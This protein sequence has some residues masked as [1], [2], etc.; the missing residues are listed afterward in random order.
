M[1]L[2]RSHGPLKWMSNFKAVAIDYEYYLTL[3]D[4]PQSVCLTERQM[5]VLS[6]QNTYTAWLTRWYNTDDITQKTVEF[7]AAEIEGL[8]MCGCGIP[9]PSVTDRINS[10][11]YNNTVSNTYITNETTYHTDGDTLNTL[12]P[13]MTY[14]GGDPADI[15]RMLCLGLEMLLKTVISQA[16]GVQDMDEN[17]QQDLVQQLG[18]AMGALAG[19]GSLA[20]AAGGSAA[21]VVAA[22]GGPWTLLGLA[23]GGIAVG[24]SSL[25]VS[26]DIAALT[27]EEAIEEVLCTLRE[28]A[29]NKEPSFAIFQGLLTPNTFDPGSNAEA[30]AAIVQPFLNNLTVYLQFMMVMSDLYAT[31][32]LAALPECAI[33]IDPVVCA[34]RDGYDFRLGNAMFTP[35]VGRASYV[36]GQGWTKGPLPAS[37][38]RIGIWRSVVPH[39]TSIT[40]V[41]KGNV[42]AV[43][44]YSSTGGVIGSLIGQD[45]IPTVVGDIY[46]WNIPV[47]GAFAGNEIM[48]DIGSGSDLAGK[49][50]IYFC[51]N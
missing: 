29:M 25:F 6:V 15:N 12:A 47:V 16:Q 45:T 26:T 22:I 10:Q 43:R 30:L 36:A 49:Y 20:I 21:L 14:A 44:L 18:I 11:V 41:T 8:L 1:S 9:V 33:C 5:Y 23:I 28:N 48:F 17:Q 2:P 38:T 32:L 7:I 31:T 35:Y 37:P 27:D 19:A 42:D 3:S 50:F 51:F 13:N 46:T 39:V 40:V 4:E 24:I 34:G